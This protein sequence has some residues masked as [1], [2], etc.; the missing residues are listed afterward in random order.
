GTEYIHETPTSSRIKGV[1]HGAGRAGARLVGRRGGCATGSGFILRRALSL[2]V[3]G[4]KTTV[5]SWAAFNQR[6]RFIDE[7][8]WQ[9]FT[10]NITY[11]KLLP[12]PLQDK[13]HTTGKT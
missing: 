13:I 10:A 4:H 6:L 11:G 3:L 9:W 12:F 2:H 7:G 8:V 5:R 1:L